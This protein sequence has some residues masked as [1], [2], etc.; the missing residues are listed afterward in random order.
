M[1]KPALHQTLF[2]L[3]FSSRIDRHA[4]PNTK[5]RNP[6]L[7]IDNNRA[8]GDVEDAVS[9]GLQ[10]TD[11]SRIHAARVAF[12]FA[13]DLHGANLWSARYRPARKQGGQQIS[14]TRVVFQS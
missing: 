2:I 1:Q 13:N 7:S 11:C 10:E 12:Q 4:A 9:A 5:R 8:D 6:R 3:S 14:Q